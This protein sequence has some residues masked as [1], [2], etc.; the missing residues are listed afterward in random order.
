MATSEIDA[1]VAEVVRRLQLVAQAPPPATE[2]AGSDRPPGSTL[3]VTNRVVTLAQLEGRLAGVTQVL[4]LPKAVVTPAVLDE[5]KQRGI[6]LTRCPK[7]AEAG[8][9]A[10]WLVVAADPAVARKLDDERRGETVLARI[11]TAADVQ[12]AVRRLAEHCRAG[13]RAVW[14]AREPFAAVAAAFGTKS[15]RAAYI[16]APNE[17]AAAVQQISA[18]VLV[19]DAARAN[20]KDIALGLERVPSG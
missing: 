20:W 10:E 17:V 4:V 3:R 11:V 15:L 13:Q 14:V 2:A 8:R 12:Q 5:L 6:R 18:N 19:F 1:I 7:L 16:T 9:G